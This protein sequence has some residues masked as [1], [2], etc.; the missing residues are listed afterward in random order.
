MLA[1]ILALSACGTGNIPARDA[2]GIATHTVTQ[3]MS[4]DFPVGERAWM[5]QTEAQGTR[6]DSTVRERPPGNDEASR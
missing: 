2:N 4:M 1:A 6:A 5:G 3:S